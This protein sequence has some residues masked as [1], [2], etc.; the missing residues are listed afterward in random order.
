MNVY[1]GTD[2]TIDL[3]QEDIMKLLPHRGPALLLD[4]ASIPK[5]NDPQVAYGTHQVTEADCV[6]HFP[7]NPIFPGIKY[8]ESLAQL[9]GVLALTRLGITDLKEKGLTPFFARIG[10]A[11][12]YKP[13][14]PGDQLDLKVF[15][16]RDNPS[17]IMAD[18]EIKC[19]EE[20]I[21]WVS[22]MLFVLK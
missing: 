8:I 2:N 10:S 14:R 1:T 17:I 16:T 15:L 5:G 20:R 4:T 11:K 3:N 19:G 13:T 9:A 12:F 21:A 7:D 18:G 6:G 22:D